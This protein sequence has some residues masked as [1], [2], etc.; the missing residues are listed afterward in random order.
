MQ[1]KDLKPDVISFSSAI[2][3]FEKAVQWRKALSCCETVRREKVQP[4]VYTCSAAISSCEKE[5]QWQEA[6]LLFGLVSRENIETNTVSYNAAI[7]SCE[8]GGSMERGSVIVQ[9]NAGWRDSSRCCKLQC[10]HFLVR[11]AL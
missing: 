4:N 3:S 7:S 1:S 8:K 10:C 5:G 2:S 6:L 9:L 11:K